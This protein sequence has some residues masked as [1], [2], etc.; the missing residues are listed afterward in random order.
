MPKFAALRPAVVG[1]ASLTTLALSV[2]LATPATAADTLSPGLPVDTTTDVTPV[3]APSPLL[4]ATG[5]APLA[6]PIGFGSATTG[7]AGGQVLHVTTAQDSYVS[8]VPGS[9]RWAVQQPGAKWIVFDSDM[10][11]P[12]VAALPLTSDTTLD[13]RGRSVTIT[14]HGLTGLVIQDVSN[15]V[16]ENLNLHDFGDT[17]LTGVNN[18][19]D[20]VSIARSSRI[21]IDHSSFSQAGDKLIGAGGG[22]QQMTLTW[23]HFFDQVQTVQIGSISTANDDVNS[24]VTLAYNHFDHVGYRT[25][26]VSYGKAHIFNNFIDTWQT[27]AVRSERLAQVY[28]DDNVFQ[29]GSARKATITTPSQICSDAGLYCDSRSGYLFD[30]GNLFLGNPLVV[31]T[32]TE[33]MFN[34]ASAY[35]YAALPATTDL[36]AQIA[37]GAGANGAGFV[38]APPLQ[39]VMSPQPVTPEVRKP[40][41][42]IRAKNIRPGRDRLIIATRGAD[43][44]GVEVTVWRDSGSTWRQVKTVKLDGRGRAHLDILDRAPGAPAKYFAEVSASRTTEPSHSNVVTVR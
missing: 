3:S 34:P 22:A 8:P 32:G 36:A 33:H 30:T 27:S 17:A 39:R 2:T 18:P 15:V 37:A 5:V 6:A 31:S 13:G 9:L 23:N 19:D 7:G 14:G 44:A 43:T 26:V 21:W 24:T 41:T 35:S 4:T 20:A 11:I 12:L 1:L 16:I 40:R 25:P 10:T 42:K 29:T 28:L 38:A